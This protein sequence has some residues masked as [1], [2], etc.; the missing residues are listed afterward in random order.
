MLLTVAT[1]LAIVSGG[2]LAYRTE[3]AMER[4][5]AVGALQRRLPGALLLCGFGLLGVMLSLVVHAPAAFGC[6]G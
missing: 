1:V 4:G 6:C 3:I 2:L 5:E